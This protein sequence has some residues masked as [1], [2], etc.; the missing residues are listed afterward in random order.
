MLQYGKDSKEHM[1]YIK[2][3][4]RQDSINLNK[5]EKYLEVHGYPDKTFGDKAT[6]TPWMIIHH[7]QGYQTREDNFKTIYKAYLDGNID[8]GTLSFYLGRM[9]QLKYGERLKMEGAYRAEDELNKLILR[10]ELT[11][12]KNEVIADSAIDDE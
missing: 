7:A 11:E 12:K 8:D 2:K 10:L 3:Q 9:Y 1:E 6:T 4:W 5:V